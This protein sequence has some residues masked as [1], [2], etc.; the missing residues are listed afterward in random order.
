MQSRTLERRIESRTPVRMTRGRGT[1]TQQAQPSSM[2]EPQHSD[3]TSPETD[4][5]T[6]EEAQLG[7]SGVR[8]GVWTPTRSQI[9]L[10]GSK[11]PRDGTDRQHF[12]EARL[13][14]RAEGQELAIC[15]LKRESLAQSL[16][17]SRWS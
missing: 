9:T 14:G 6:Q 7:K 4:Y 16:R 13:A 3:K 11:R 1:K 15:V 12:L 5:G 2:K 8:G 10:R 17:T